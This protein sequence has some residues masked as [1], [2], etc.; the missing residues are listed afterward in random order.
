MFT[1]V[2]Y[3]ITIFLTL[4]VVSG[5]SKVLVLPEGMKDSKD[6]A[7]I[8][9]KRPKSSKS[10]LSCTVNT[11]AVITAIDGRGINTSKY[12]EIHLKPGKYQL[13]VSCGSAS[14]VGGV[15]GISFGNSL[16]SK[17]MEDKGHVGVLRKQHVSTYDMNLMP[18]SSH[19]VTLWDPMMPG[20]HPKKDGYC[21]FF[22]RK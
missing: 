9:Q 5:C 18:G 3:A 2:F 7:V 13:E 17:S 6:L 15:G 16:L 14:L 8:D 12:D 19:W 11:F 22:T 10:C 1:R 4:L 20:P 21:L